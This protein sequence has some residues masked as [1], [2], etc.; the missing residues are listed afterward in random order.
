MGSGC[1]TEATQGLLDQE[2]VDTAIAI[3]EGVDEDEAKTYGNAVHAVRARGV[4]WPP[5]W[6][7]PLAQAKEAGS[8]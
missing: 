2:P 1:S 7:H 4:P 6:S 5:A 3:F 8:E